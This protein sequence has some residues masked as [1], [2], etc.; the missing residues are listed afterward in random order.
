MNERRESDIKN[1]GISRWF[2][3]IH[4]G[5]WSFCTFQCELFIYE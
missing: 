4:S 2:R 1:I 3:S 5:T